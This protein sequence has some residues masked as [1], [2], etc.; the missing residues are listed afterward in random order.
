MEVE[1]NGEGSSE[2]ECSDSERSTSSSNSVGSANTGDTDNTPESSTT[3]DTTA[4]GSKPF[5]LW[6]EDEV[7]QWAC[8][9]VKE[10]HAKVLLDNEVD[11]SILCGKLAQC[12]AS[13]LRRHS[14]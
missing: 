4:E 3:L 11:G 9:V 14:C 5:E 1:A 6:T 12:P 10:N 7:Y 8:T 13:Q 2:P